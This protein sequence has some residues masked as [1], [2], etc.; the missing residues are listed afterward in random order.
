[1]RIDKSKV[2]DARV[3]RLWG[4]HPPIIVDEEIKEALE[5]TG[6]VGGLFDEV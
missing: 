1:L 6:I 5:R 2:G 4:W 3:F